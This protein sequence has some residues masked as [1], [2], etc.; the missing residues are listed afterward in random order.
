MFNDVLAGNFPVNSAGGTGHHNLS[1]DLSCSCASLI[2]DLMLGPLAN[3]GGPTLT[4]ALRPLSPAIDAGDTSVAPATDQ[5]GLP[6]PFGYSADV[7]AFEYWPPT[8]ALQVIPSSRGTEL[9]GSGIPGESC[10]LF[11]STNLAAWTVVAT[12]QFGAD[13]TVYFQAAPTGRPAIF[14]RLALP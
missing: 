8:P 6:R 7:G 4:M 14:Y 10:R 5:R 2:P 13:G 3:N 12:N 9:I 1:T 11:S